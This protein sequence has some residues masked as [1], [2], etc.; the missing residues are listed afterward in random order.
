VRQIT[1][2]DLTIRY[3]TGAQIVVVG[4]D[5]PQRMEGVAWDGGVVD[6]FAEVKATAWGQTIRPALST[7]GR[8]GW[9]WFIGRPKGRGHFYELWRDAKQKPGWQSFHWVS[10]DI[11]PAEEIEAAQRDLDP[12]T[13]RQEYEADWV[14]FEGLAY[15][16]WDP[17]KHLTQLEYDPAQPL[18]FCFDF[19][20]DPGV[21]VVAQEQVGRTSII[22]EVWI[23]R[24]SNT[25]AVC[26]RLI[27]DWS[28]HK[29]PVLLYGDATGG[30]RDTRSTT[31]DWAIIRD[32]LRPTFADT[33]LRV[34]VGVG[35]PYERDRVNSVNTRLCNAAGDV[36]LVVDPRKAPHVVSDFE[37][38]TLLEGGSGELDKDKDPML[39]HLTD[40]LGYYIHARYPIGGH[41]SSTG[42]LVS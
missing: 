40:A 19:N 4:L 21:A 3:I 41:A 1:E 25:P 31:N 39:T 36:R 33:R 28:H 38:V 16:Q 26:R 18:V 34:G 20:V 10:A 22:G 30:R 23:P 27:Q 15:Y 11:L 2:T 12:L 6:E 5:K 37:G 42:A 9:C 8:E 32:H 35:N 29:G 17:S 24:S 14:N 13:Y 7:R